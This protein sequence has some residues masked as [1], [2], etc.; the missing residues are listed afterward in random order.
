MPTRLAVRQRRRVWAGCRR[1]SRFRYVTMKGGL[2]HEFRRRFAVED[3][4]TGKKMIS[5][6]LRR[7][8]FISP[9]VQKLINRFSSFPTYPSHPSHS[10]NLFSEHAICPHGILR[11]KMKVKLRSVPKLD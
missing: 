4:R 1:L 6:G 2:D 5:F 8:S 7:S 3:R 9:T 10:K 11:E